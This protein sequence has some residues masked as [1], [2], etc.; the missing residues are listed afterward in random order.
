M[1]GVQDM[2][3]KMNMADKAKDESSS[4]EEDN[5]HQSSGVGGSGSS[6]ELKDQVAE[7]QLPEDK[8]LVSDSEF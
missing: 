1:G 7:D 2:K 6:G 8:E 3:E 5:Q 4:E